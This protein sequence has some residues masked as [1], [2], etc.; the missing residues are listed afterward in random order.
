MALLRGEQRRRWHRGEGIRV[1]DYLRQFPQLEADPEGVLDL[2]YT[3]FVLREELR[4]APR[5][6]EYLERFPRFADPLRRQ[7]DL[8]QAL[9]EEARNVATH[10]SSVRGWPMRAAKP[11]R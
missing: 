6:E 9:Q 8:H 5:P 2:I 1:E 3:E 7:F 4:Q 10:C 11:L